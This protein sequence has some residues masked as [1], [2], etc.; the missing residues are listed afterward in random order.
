MGGPNARE[1]LSMSKSPHRDM[2]EDESF[3]Q[4]NPRML[5]CGYY[6]SEPG[7]RHRPS[8]P[9]LK[10]VYLWYIAGG[11]GAVRLDGRWVPFREGD[12]LTFLLN[13]RYE[14]E[15]AD[16][17]L[18]SEIYF[19][20]IVPAA[21]ASRPVNLRLARGWPA[22]LA[23]PQ[24]ARMRALFAESFETFTLKPDRHP[25]RLKAI[26]LEVL[27]VLLTPAAPEG[28]ALS[29]R[30]A[31]KLAQAQRFIEDRLDQPLDPER[32]ADH[33]N[34]S[35]SYLYT[36]FRRHVGQS[37]MQYLGEVR[38][39]RAAAILAQGESVSNTAR[40]TG[41]HSLHYFSRAFRHRYGLSPTRFALQLRTK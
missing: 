21:P 31:A 19:S 23:C 26:L 28:E 32:M 37:P 10:D 14:D 41:F 1:A 35:E 39:R 5:I 30:T 8:A 4:W 17:R 16:A 2:S 25:L 40:R 24:P 22:R 34:L 13:Q 12:F 18:G 7:Y 3:W 27:G 15:R 36:L 20:Y 9:F 33:A 11:A 6:R 38:L 29:P